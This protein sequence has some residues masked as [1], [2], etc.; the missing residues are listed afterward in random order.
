LVNLLITMRC[1]RACSYCF[2]KEKLHSYANSGEIADITLENLNKVKDFLQKSNCNVIQLAGGEPTIHP[3]FDEILLTLISGRFRVNLLSNALWDPALNRLFEDISPNFLGFLL[4]IDRPSNYSHAEWKRIEENLLFLSSRGNITLSFNI[5][6]KNPDYNYIFDIISSY[7]FK[8]LRLSFAMPVVFGERKNSFLS[9]EDYKS[10]AKHITDFVNRAEELN[11]RVGLDNTVPICMFT[12]EELSN[13][14][15]KQVIEP[16]RNFV[17][18]PALDIGPDL[19]VWRCFGT[20][21]LFNKKLDDFNSVEEIYAYYIRTSRLYQFK[22]LP[23]KECETC[24]HAQKERC[25]GGCIGFAEMNSKQ[26]GLTVQEPTDDEIL[27]LRP[28][29]SK[30]ATIRRYRL[31]TETVMISLPDNN[32][33]EVKPSAADLLP[34]FNGKRTVREVLFSQIQE[35]IGSKEEDMLGRSAYKNSKPKNPASN[36]KHD[37]QE[38]TCNLKT[39][40]K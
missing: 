1:N 28:V 13:L 29:L 35:T 14:L 22:F 5:F 30:Q 3:K 40:R 21:T 24:E 25:Q 33:L 15:I 31:P 37:R 32:Q 2:A 12:P 27:E 8:N 6:E 23:F 38:S 34:M 11:A 36:K 26:L 18:S 17:C 7:K 9:I 20:S 19:S 16:S 10:A 4:N 39:G